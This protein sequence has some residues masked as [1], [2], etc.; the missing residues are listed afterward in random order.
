MNLKDGIVSLSGFL[1]ARIL[2]Q[3]Q[4]QSLKINNCPQLIFEFGQE[5][6]RRD[7]ICKT[8]CSFAL[9]SPNSP[10]NLNFDPSSDQL[11]A[12]LA[13]TPAGGTPTTSSILSTSSSSSP[14]G[15]G[16]ITTP[17]RGPT[18]QTIFAGVRPPTPPSPPRPQRPPVAPVTFDSRP[19]SQPIVPPTI[20]T[21]SNVNS[22]NNN[23][24]QN[25]RPP[26]PPQLQQPQQQQVNPT[27]QPRPL[28]NFL[29]RLPNLSELFGL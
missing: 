2:F 11:Q 16:P 26:P 14:L 12:P 6:V 18:V 5:A 20:V 9:N 24:N 23:N 8:Q 10:S 21:S 25:N 4:C 17:I 13:L 27:R 28:F 1:S 29:P 22:N 15:N 19:S 3:A 7:N